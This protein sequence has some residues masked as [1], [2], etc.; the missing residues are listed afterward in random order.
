MK[1]AQ[2][3]PDCFSHLVSLVQGLFPEVELIIQVA[4]L[5]TE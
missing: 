2:I 3:T 1:M 5:L 4:L